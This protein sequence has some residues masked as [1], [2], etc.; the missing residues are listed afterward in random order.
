MNRPIKHQY[1]LDIA[2]AVS[3]RSTCLRRRY[4]AVIVSN[5]EIIAT[6]YNGSPRGTLNCLEKFEVCPRAQNDTPH[7]SGDYSDC[8]SVHAEQNAIISAARKDMLG[9]TLYLACTDPETGEE[10]EEAPTCCPICQRMVLNAGIRA[11]IARNR[12]GLVNVLLT[13]HIRRH[14]D[15]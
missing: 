7:N 4:G 12:N 5:D 11:V 15:D 13:D 10:R 6:G 8:R 2:K 1:Y 14:F 3:E 9:A